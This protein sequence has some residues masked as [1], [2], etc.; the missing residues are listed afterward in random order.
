MHP[1]RP[2][3]FTALRAGWVL[4]RL[5]LWLLC[6]RLSFQCWHRLPRS[7]LIGHTSFGR[8]TSSHGVRLDAHTI[9]YHLA[10]LIS[11]LSHTPHA[12]LLSGHREHLDSTRPK[13]NA[14]LP[15]EAHL[16]PLFPT[17]VNS[18]IQPAHPKSGWFW[19]S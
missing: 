17:S 13:L 6:P 19:P 7:L 8:F 18:T 15:T 1:L 3:P 9:N 5:W 2:M 11:L 4:F 16:S 12:Q 14:S 10:T